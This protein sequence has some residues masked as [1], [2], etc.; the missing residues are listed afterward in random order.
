MEFMP[1]VSK[2]KSISKFPHAEKLKRILLEVVMWNDVDPNN[3][4]YAHA[5]L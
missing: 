5:Q 1:E 4:I 2:T 3:L